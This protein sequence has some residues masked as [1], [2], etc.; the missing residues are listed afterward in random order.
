MKK[1][2]FITIFFLAL[3]L[4]MFY[5]VLHILSPFFQPI[6]WAMILTFAFYPLHDRLRKGVGNRENLAAALTTCLIFLA[7]VPLAIYIVLHLAEEALKLS[8]YAAE[9]VRQGRLEQALADL[10]RTEWIQNIE[11]RFDHWGAL[12]E[13]LRI[14]AAQSAN[15]SGG[16]IARN[17]GVITVNAFLTLLGTLLTL[18][19]VFFFLRDG[20]R[21]YRYI[22]D[23]TPM[24]ET[25]KIMVFRQIS[26]TFSAVLRGQLFTALAQASILGIVFWALGL[27]LPVFFAA[28]TILAALIPFF[29]TPLVWLP[30]VGYL[31]L[32][33]QYGKAAVLLALGVFVIGLVD[34]LLKPLLIGEKTKLPYMLLFLGILGGIRVYGFVGAFLAPA[35]ISLFFVLIKIYR[36]KYQ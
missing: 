22:Y 20:H 1:E 10:R 28:C 24:E 27:P 3:L 5:E 12:K 29:G 26:D 2:H 13:N 18:F 16:F 8:H 31:L 32:T 17:A 15:A 19:L 7:F 6:F 23:I 14:W 30:F 9:A 33:Q 35:V 34:N 36:E 21:I 25:N 4:F 11:T